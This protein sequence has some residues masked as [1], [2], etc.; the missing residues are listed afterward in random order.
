MP[1]CSKD[2]LTCACD[3]HSGARLLRV[4]LLPALLVELFVALGGQ[5]GVQEVYEAVP[6]VALVLVVYGQVEEI[7]LVPAQRLARVSGMGSAPSR[8]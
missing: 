5:L 4:E 3:S 6:K 2:L 8:G 1:R 7:I